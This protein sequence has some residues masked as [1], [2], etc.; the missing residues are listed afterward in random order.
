MVLR[1]TFIIALLASAASAADWTEYRMGPFRVISNAGDRPA[2]E[3]LTQMEQTRHVLAGMLGKTDLTTVWPIVLVLFPNQKE[4]APHALPQPFVP[5]GSSDLSAWTADT[6]Q[7]LDW[8]RDIVHR[9]IADNAGL[10]S[11]VTVTALEDLFSTIEVNATRVKL[12]ARPPS[13]PADRE[14]EWAR[15]QLLATNPEYAGRFRVYL[16]NLQQGSEESIAAHNG[17]DMTLEELNRR[18]D[19]YFRAG[20]F[21]ASPVSGEALNPNRDFIEKRLPQSDVDDWLAEL[22]AAGKTFSPVSPRGLLAAGAP[23]S[24]EQ[25]A[26]ANPRWAEPHARLAALETNRLV[27]VSRLKVATTLE[28]NNSAYWQALAEAQTEAEQPTDAAKSW[29]SAERTAPSAAERARIHQI[30]LDAEQRRIDFEIAEKKRAADERAQDLQRVKDAAAAEVRAA[31]AKANREQGGLKSGA[32]P[33]PFAQIYGGETVSG[34][35]VQVEC[36]NGPRR[37]TI[38]NAKSTVKVLIRG[39]EGLNPADFTCG[40]QKPARQVMVIHDA[41]PDTQLGTIG[42]VTTYELR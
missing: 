13:L 25:A 21:E 4:Y 22:K 8:R 3:R 39:T 10:L 23:V 11:G 26:K 28:P 30:R 16:G 17:F 12:G 1:T 35:L 42:N 5:G 29:I 2:R 32:T 6:P 19:E 40:V 37:L 27:K 7:P 9:L 24:L 38:Q 15:I 31:E 36:L 34:A 20:V 14:R 33:V 41:K 18:A